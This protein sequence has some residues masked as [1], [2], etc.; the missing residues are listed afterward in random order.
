MRTVATINLY[1]EIFQWTEGGATSM[2]AKIAQAEKE[3]DEIALHIHC[4]GGSVVE[5]NMIVDAIRNC[6]IPVIAYV[7]GIAASMAAIVLSVATKAYM[8]E[9][10]LV[11]IHAPAAFAAGRG[12]ADEHTQIANLLTA[13]EAMFVRTLAGRTG[14][15]EEDV[16]VWMQGEN[17]FS[18]EQ[19]LA[20]GLID[21]IVTPVTR[22]PEAPTPEQIMS[23]S[24]ESIYGYFTARLQSPINKPKTNDMNLQERITAALQMKGTV[25]DEQLVAHIADMQAKAKE[26]D[27]LR[28]RVDAYETAEKERKDAA[29]AGL[30]DGAI[31]GRKITADMRE[32]YLGFARADYEGTKAILDK[33]PAAADLSE[34]GAIKVPA[35]DAWA[36]RKAEIDRNKQNR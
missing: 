35:A 28:V 4:Y 36:L 1:S 7:D 11:M 2:V 16:K 34:A 26:A 32:T 20:D 24:V 5:G 30:V 17:W 8:S 10:A 14:K 12:T 22:N 21:G 13:M 25:S 27:T 31:E 15:S 6:K 18:A 23:G 33:M 19:A 3:A 9:N 29:C